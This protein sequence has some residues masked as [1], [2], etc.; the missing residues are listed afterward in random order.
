MHFFFLINDQTISIVLH[1]LLNLEYLMKSALNANKNYIIN[2]NTIIK[3]I[4]LEKTIIVDEISLNHY[5]VLIAIW[6]VKSC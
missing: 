1:L 5:W 6:I 2:N 3:N 4:Y